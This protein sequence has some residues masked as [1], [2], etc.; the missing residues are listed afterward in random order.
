MPCVFYG[1]VSHSCYLSYVFFLALVMWRIQSA[2][3]R[4]S[5][6]ENR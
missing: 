5:K 1:G 6:I 4:I 3:E 2:T